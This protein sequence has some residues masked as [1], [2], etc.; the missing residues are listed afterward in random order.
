M[1]TPIQ[2]RDDFKKY[3]LKKLGEPVIKINIDDTQIQDRINDA[4]D[5][6]WIFHGDGS[7]K[8][9]VKYQV[10]QTDINNGFITLPENVLSVIKVVPYNTMAST[11]NLEYFAFMSDI[12]SSFY[13]TNNN[14]S[15]DDSRGGGYY[16]SVKGYLNNLADLFVSV[17]GL[18]FIFIE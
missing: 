18:Q 6:F 10:E 9:Y 11:V 4:L 5:Y 1:Y 8:L 7:Y 13:R 3:C 17:P 2:S 12:I 16:A 14:C 15:S